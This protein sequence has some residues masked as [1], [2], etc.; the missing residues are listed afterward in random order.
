LE[1]T[2]GFKGIIQS[3]ANEALSD[4]ESEV[5][6]LFPQVAEEVPNLSKKELECFLALMNS[7]SKTSS[8]FSLSFNVS[9]IENIWIIDSGVTDHMTPHSSYFSSLQFI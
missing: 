2:R 4:S 9:S 8:Y 3:R 6:L 1:R 7:L 5:A